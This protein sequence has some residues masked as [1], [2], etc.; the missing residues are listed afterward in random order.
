MSIPVLQGDFSTAKFR[1]YVLQMM[2]TIT[3]SG[4]GSNAQLGQI[5]TDVDQISKATQGPD[6]NGAYAVNLIQTSTGNYGLLPTNSDGKL[7]AVPL[8]IESTTGGYNSLVVDNGV[9]RTTDF[10]SPTG[11][12]FNYSGQS[13]P[14]F[15]P[16][17]NGGV[18]KFA[19]STGTNNTIIRTQ[20]VNNGDPVLLLYGFQVTNTATTDRFVKF[21]ANNTFTAATEIL[22]FCIH[23]GQSFSYT[24]IAPIAFHNYL[25]F[26]FSTAYATNVAVALND[27]FININWAYGQS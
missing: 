12:L 14:A 21:Y 22:N 9:L 27:L 23:Q 24:P 5:V 17:T 15:D 4:T 18:Y 11:I 20:N 6:G 19:S 10:R 26:N 13:V 1:Q 7:T 16:V 8:A 3:G 2:Q 25:S